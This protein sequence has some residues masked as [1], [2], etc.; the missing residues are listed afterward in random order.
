M[1]PT[2]YTIRPE[3]RLKIYRNL[4][5]LPQINLCNPHD[6]GSVQG[7]N[8]VD[9]GPI[10]GCKVKVPPQFLAIFSVCRLFHE[11][12]LDVLW[13]ENMFIAGEYRRC[14]NAFFA[15]VCYPERIKK[16]TF[17]YLDHYTEENGSRI[18]EGAPN[19]TDVVLLGLFNLP[20]DAFLSWMQLPIGQII[21]KN[22]L[23]YYRFP[24]FSQA[25]MDRFSA[26]TPNMKI[27]AMANMSSDNIGDEDYALK[28]RILPVSKKSVKAEK[29]P[30]T[31]E[32]LL[33]GFQ[34]RFNMNFPDCYEPT[35]S[36]YSTDLDDDSDA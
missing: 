16:M 13:G 17:R 33:I 15:K 11:E 34:N 18:I 8:G 28:L 19:L 30:R 2:L 27:T 25:Q 21:P 29:L 35:T 12:A 14:T 5:I 3:L 23:I 7:N 9:Y 4:L 22:S 10:N 24:A 1:P 6:T 36:S 26:R 20:R 32:L 31:Y